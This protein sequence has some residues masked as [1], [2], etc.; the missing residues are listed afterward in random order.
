MKSSLCEYATAIFPL[1]KLVSIHR[2]LG[3]SLTFFV[4]IGL[5]SYLKGKFAVEI[6]NLFFIQKCI[7]MDNP[8]FLQYILYLA[9]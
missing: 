8:L 9:R 6:F 2:G 7:A 1:D 3:C 4:S 5:L